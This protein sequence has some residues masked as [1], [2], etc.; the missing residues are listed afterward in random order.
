MVAVV[1]PL[2]NGVLTLLPV[3]FCLQVHGTSDLPV[4]GACTSIN[5]DIGSPVVVIVVHM[6]KCLEVQ[7][8]SRC[9]HAVHLQPQSDHHC[10]SLALSAMRYPTRRKIQP[11]T[12]TRRSPHHL[13]PRRSTYCLE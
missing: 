1:W 8:L 5:H 9:V 13:R 2:F 11:P 3:I 10:T 6:T 7:L 4:K 12:A